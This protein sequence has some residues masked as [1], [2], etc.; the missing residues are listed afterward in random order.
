MQKKMMYAAIAVVVVIVVAA[1]GVV[2]LNQPGSASGPNAKIVL[3]KKTPSSVAYSPLD[4]NA[5]YNKSYPLSRFLYL[6][7]NGVPSNT[8]SLHEWLAY[9]YNAQ[10]GGK[11][12]DNAGFYVLQ[13]SDMNA[14]LAQLSHPNA[15]GPSGD[16]K[17][18][19]STTM[20]EVA[21]LWEAG[22]KA[23]TGHT[24]TLSAGG[25]GVGI[26]QFLAGTI[27]VAQ[28]SRAMTP[29]EW[30]TAKT[31]HI[32]CTEWKVAVDGL[33]IIVNKDNPVTTL[34]LE[35][36]EGLFNGT[37]KYWDDDQMGG[38]HVAVTLYG[39][40]D[41]SGSYASFKDLV[42]VHPPKAYAS[43]MLQ[44]NSNAL[45]LPEVE[46]DKGGVGYV[47]IGYAKEASGQSSTASQ[48]S[49]ALMMSVDGIKLW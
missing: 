9:I 38:N 40:D 44:A 22:F 46:N 25:S 17:E 16:F 13:Q 7:T 47:G 11:D 31:N 43:S 30:A 6:Y 42:L 18:G 35:Q 36:L 33:S 10:Q 34:N 24:V 3:I 29:A 32:N 15:T 26:Q 39:R 41:A 8:S 48:I 14:M 28:A 20:T 4:V 19:G 12:I 5:V 1:V 23:A 45:I 49:A 21:N 2:L 27:D 37:Y